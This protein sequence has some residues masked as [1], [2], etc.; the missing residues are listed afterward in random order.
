MPGSAYRA[1][2]SQGDPGHRLPGGRA[3]AQHAGGVPQVVH[4]SLGVDRVAGGQDAIR[5]PRADTRQRC[6]AGPAAPLRG[7]CTL[8]R[9]AH[10]AGLG[11]WWAATQAWGRHDAFFDLAE[12]LAGMR[13]LPRME[14]HVFDA[15]HF[16]LETH[17]AGATALMIEFIRRSA[18]RK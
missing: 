6:T 17:A 1:G 13:S 18:D 11:P 5:A 9:A 12:T 4:Q 16:L 14:A 8:R 3:A 10:R 7:G 15:G 2:L